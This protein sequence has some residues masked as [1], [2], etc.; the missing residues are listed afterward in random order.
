MATT[1]HHQVSINAPVAKVYEAISTADGISTWWDKQTPVQ[2][3]RGLVLEHNPGPEHGIVKL[4]VVELVPDKRV[5][6][7]CI[8]T[9]PESSPA[10]VWTGTHFI[11]ELA[12]RDDIAGRI[13]ILDFY[14]T[15]Y[16]E[17]SEFF[18]FNNSAWGQVVQNLK[19]VVESQR[20]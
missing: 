4:R 1:I 16:D 6:W 9:H 14:Q 5:E 18:G 11:F 19:Q 3:D 12:E 17:R 2:T 7:E 10:S 13:T 20:G 8:S 15:G